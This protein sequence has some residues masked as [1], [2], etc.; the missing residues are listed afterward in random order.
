VSEV[1]ASPWSWIRPVPLAPNEIH[2]WRIALDAP[3]AEAAGLRTLLSDGER[4][5]AARFHFE[6]DR[7]RFIVAH[8]AL[9]TLLAHYL[10]AEA[11]PDAFHPGPNGK[12]ALAAGASLRFNLAHS[13]DLALVALTTGREIGVDLEAVDERVELEGVARRFF[14]TE[15][16][17]GLF[18]LPGDRRLE[19]FFHIWAQKE[20]YLKARGD[21]V[22][23][24]LDH[25]DVSTDPD[26]PAALLTDRKEPEARGG[27]TLLSLAPGAGFRGAVAVEGAEP[28]VRRFGWE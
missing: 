22:A 21:G 13:R 10:G 5:R 7:T 9:R 14:S 1:P 3:P 23:F 12:P 2:V 20:A 19:A 28:Q 4:D 15:E 18:R 25:F 27:W 8:A 6:R 17:R 24:G 26:K 11:H 16:C